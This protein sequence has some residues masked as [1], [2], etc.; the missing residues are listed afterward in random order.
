MSHFESCLIC[1]LLFLL[2]LGKL[3]FSSS[4]FF[5]SLCVSRVFSSI[6]YIYVLVFLVLL[7]ENRN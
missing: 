5:P 6:L 4:F 7:I 1:G 2:K 3:E